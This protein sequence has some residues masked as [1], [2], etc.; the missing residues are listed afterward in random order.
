MLW[1]P[2]V[3]LDRAL[4]ERAV[5]RA[6]RKGLPSVDAYV[7]ELLERDLKAA[8]EQVQRDTVTEKMKGLGYLQ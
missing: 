8:D 7:V 5:E 4:Y 6:R 1:R 2:K 3:R